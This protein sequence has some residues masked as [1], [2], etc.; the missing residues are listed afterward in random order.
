MNQTDL[1]TTDTD[2][3]AIFDDVHSVPAEPAAFV[4]LQ[5]VGIVLTYA[6]II[7]VVVLVGVVAVLAGTLLWPMLMDLP[8]L[9]A[10]S[11]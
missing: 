1:G 3:L 2:G 11:G 5:L 8:A 9:S 4:G 10:A 7:G 6:F